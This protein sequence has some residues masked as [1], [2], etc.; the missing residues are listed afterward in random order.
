MLYSKFLIGDDRYLIAINQITVI[1]PYVNLKLVPSMPDYAAGLLNYHGL[2]IPVI[3]L[4]QLLDARPCKK[5]LSTRIIVVNIQ[6]RKG[7]GKVEVGLLV[8]NATETFSANDDGFVEPGMKNPE[9][10]FVGDVI[11][12]DEGMVT[13]IFPQDIF[14][15]IDEDLFFPEDQKAKGC[16]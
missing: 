3:D 2:S 9:M 15:K 13:R 12:D 8:E 11:N 6:S 14:S 7:R 5:I 10:P 16:G 4:C 1:I